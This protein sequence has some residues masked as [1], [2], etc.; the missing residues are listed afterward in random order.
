MKKIILLFI[1]LTGFTFSLVAQ[2]PQWINYTNGDQISALAFDGNNWMVY[3]TSNSG[4]PE[5]D[6]ISSIVIE[7]NVT[8][9]I[10]GFVF[11]GGGGPTYKISLVSFDGNSWSVYDTSNC[12]LPNHLINAIAIDDVGTKWI[13][14]G[15]PQLNEGGLAVFDNNNWT[16]Y[17]TSNSG[18]P[19]NCLTSVAIDINGTKWI[20]TGFLVGSISGGEGLATFDG[21]EWVHYNTSNSQLPSD[22]VYEIAIDGIDTKWIGTTD[23]LATYDGNDWLVF[24]TSNSGL[25]YNWVTSIAIDGNDT[26]WIGTYYYNMCT[27]EDGI[28][29][30]S[31]DGNNWVQYDTSNSEL[32]NNWITTIAVENNEMIWIGTEGGGLASFDGFNWTIYNKNNSALTSNWIGSVAIDNNGTKWIGSGGDLVAFNENG[33]PVGVEDLTADNGQSSVLIYP[34]PASNNISLV[35]QPRTEIISLEILD[36]QGKI[37]LHKDVMDNSFS[38]KV[39][40]YPRGLYFVRILTSEG[41]EVEKLIIQ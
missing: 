30:T 4:L 12:D 38:V 26:K 40:N 27:G 35:S 7:D 13:G 19:Y 24:N 33:I 31:F 39:S 2:E 41:M 14:T 36:I 3:D 29:L 21:S 11:Q 8:K 23:G 10:G 6:D 18:L 25:P 28:S 20:G 9:W 16:I 1:V 17:N 5:L 37:I 32:P 15:T 34:N 22:I